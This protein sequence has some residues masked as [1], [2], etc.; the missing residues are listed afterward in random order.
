MPLHRRPEFLLL[1]TVV[2]WGLNFPIIKVALG[3]MPPFVVNALRFVASAAV[4]GA[5]H[6]AEA[7][8][9]GRSFWAPLRRYPARIVGLGLLGYVGYQ[10]C[11]I[12]GVDRTTAGSAAL[13]IASAPVWTAL[14]A[15][16]LGVERLP[17]GAWAG[18]VVGFAG[19]VL[20]VFGSADRVDLSSD[21]FVGNALML[22]AAVA[23]AAYTVLSRPLMDRG[24]GATGLAFFG[25]LVALPLLW[26]LGWWAW[27]EADW[28]AVGWKEWG[29]ILFSGGLSTGAAYSWW[30]VAVKA[31]GPSPTAIWSNLV[32]VV[33]LASGVVIL[34]EAVTAAQLGG[35]ALILG[36]LVVMRRSRSRAPARAGVG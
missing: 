26:G 22:G 2:V 24:V 27:P 21:T 16:A 5:M 3:P 8:R 28:A 6:A 30:N 33:A 9:E 25:L 31:V 10:L 7:R 1:L 14:G 12:V 18:L 35:G 36:G 23:W 29:A 4:L 19:T 32:P 11:F 15:R 34:G 13:I 20:V 17:L